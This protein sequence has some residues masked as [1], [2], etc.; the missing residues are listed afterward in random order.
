MDYIKKDVT[1][2]DLRLDYIRY[3]LDGQISIATDLIAALTEMLENC[4]NE[5]E[6]DGDVNNDND[7]NDDGI[8][9]D[10]V[11]DD[12]DCNDDTNDDDDKNS[13]VGKSKRNITKQIISIN[14]EPLKKRQRG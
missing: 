11:D 5:E 8:D 13:E 12:N 4:D 7:D 9:D 14:E 2:K 10:D 6:S 1:I 3:Y